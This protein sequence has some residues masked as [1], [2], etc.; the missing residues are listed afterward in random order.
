[1]IT[2]FDGRQEL[3][4]GMTCPFDTAAQAGGRSAPRFEKTPTKIAHFD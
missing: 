2:R 3:L 4:G 1:M